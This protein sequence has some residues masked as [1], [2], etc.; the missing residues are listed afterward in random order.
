M[1]LERDLGIRRAEQ[2]ARSPHRSQI[3]VARLERESETDAQA[4]W[5]LV[6]V[7]GAIVVLMASISLA[8]ASF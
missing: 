7:A 4:L 1:R 2:T 3:A 8:L 5:D 6:S